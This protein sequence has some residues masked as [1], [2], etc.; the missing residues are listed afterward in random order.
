MGIRL[1]KATK[2]WTYF[3][4]AFSPSPWYK[5]NNYSPSNKI[6]LWGVNLSFGNCAMLNRSTFVLYPSISKYTFN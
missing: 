4:N 3:P 6:R 2:D 1:K 5:L